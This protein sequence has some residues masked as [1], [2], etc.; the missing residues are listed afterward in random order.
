MTRALWITG[1]GWASGAVAAGFALAGPMADALFFGSTAGL[2]L[3]GAA[4]AV[5]AHALLKKPG[6]KRPAVLGLVAGLAGLTA[7]AVFFTF[8]IAVASNG[9][10]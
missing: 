6:P 2:L 5:A 7:A 1:V 4:V 9:G 10:A 3:H 8:W